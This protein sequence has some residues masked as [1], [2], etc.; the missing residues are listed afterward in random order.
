[1]AETKEKYFTT[2]DG[3]ELA[4]HIKG[5]GQKTLFC[6]NGIGVAKWAWE[7]LEEYLS[8]KFKIVTWDYRGHG[9]SKDPRRTEKITFDDLVDDALEL[10]DSLKIKN[11]IL[12]GHSSGLHVA[13]EVMRR[14]PKL[15]RGLISCLGTPGKT[16]ESFMDSFWG[17]LVFDVAYILNAVIPETSRW[18]NTNL[19]SSP[20]T[21]QIGAALNL[22]NPAIQAKK[23]VSRYLEHFT[24]INFGLFSNLIASESKKSGRDLLTKIKIPAL[25]I[26]AEFDQ[27]VP[28]RIA[29][30]MNRRIKKSDL[31]VIRKGTH[32]ALFE[33]P[34][35]FNVKIEQ[36]LKKLS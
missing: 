27:F 11:A 23:E 14:R 26:A 34:D 31:F 21:Y 7:P 5:K 28:L 16:L 17:Q 1:M 9:D 10:I 22:V 8:N 18:I 6:F 15:A 19:L 30:D 2:L 12:L 25:L 29:K 4:Y 20:V 33:Q 3:V 24:R 13:L 32:A 36:F 35:I